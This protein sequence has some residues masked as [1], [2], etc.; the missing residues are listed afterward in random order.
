MFKIDLEFKS[1]YFAKE[2]YYVKL[3]ICGLKLFL[4]S[5]KKLLPWTFGKHVKLYKPYACHPAATW[6]LHTWSTFTDTNCKFSASF[7]SIPV[8]NINIIKRETGEF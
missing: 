8:Y 5:S 6:W 2:I 4:N 1:S 3:N 7:I